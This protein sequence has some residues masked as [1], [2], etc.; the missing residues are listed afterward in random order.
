M[1][2]MKTLK[3]FLLVLGTI[4]VSST[5]YSCL[6]DDEGYSLG[7]FSVG[8]VTV[9]PISGDTYY[10]QLDDST[11][12]WPSNGVKPYFGLDKE[13]RAFANFTVLG[14]GQELNVDYDYVIRLNRIDSVL[15]K[16][17]AEDLGEKNDE[18]YGNDPIW[19]KSAWIEDGYLTFQFES[20]FDGVTKHFINLV[21]MEGSDTYELEFRHNAFNSHSGGKGWGLASFR[22]NSL[23][24]T[25]GETVKMKIKYKDYEGEKVI[26]LDYKSGSSSGK[27]PLMGADNFHV[28][29]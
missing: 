6:D 9:K 2:A 19:M 29:N 13:R 4:L 14:K 16:S 7:N 28:T 25:N 21:K 5:L 24:D 22:L 3:T 20:Y 11:S 27:A 18:Y 17:I 23:P 10:L 26:E 12:L 8:V 15:T 1:N